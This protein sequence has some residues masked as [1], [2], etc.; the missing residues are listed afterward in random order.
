MMRSYAGFSRR[1]LMVDAQTYRRKELDHYRHARSAVF[2][3]LTAWNL[4]SLDGCRRMQAWSSPSLQDCQ[5]LDVHAI[6]PLGLPFGIASSFLL[7]AH[8]IAS[9]P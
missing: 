4:P 2:C 3:R 8:S 6:R 9:L 1:I 7:S 5:Y